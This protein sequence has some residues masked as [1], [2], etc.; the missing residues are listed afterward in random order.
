MPKIKDSL[1]TAGTSLDVSARVYGIRVDDAHLEGMKLANMMAQIG[2]KKAADQD[3]GKAN[4]Y[5]KNN[6]NLL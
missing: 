2:N 4:S 6:I 1:Q 5:L 3:M